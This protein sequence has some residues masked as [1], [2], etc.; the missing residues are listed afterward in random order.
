[1]LLQMMADE[2]DTVLEDG[3]AEAVAKDIVKLWD[4]LSRSESLQMVENWE[5]R[6]QKSKGKRVEYI[7]KGKRC[8]ILIITYFLTI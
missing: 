8:T 2:Y 6:M 3:S 1:M 7:D 5:G 4:N